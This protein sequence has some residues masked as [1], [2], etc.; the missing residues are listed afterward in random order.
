MKHAVELLRRDPAIALLAGGALVMALVAGV[1]GGPIGFL[2]VLAAGIAAAGVF[3]GGRVMRARL[4]NRRAGPFAQGL[5]DNLGTAGISHG[6]AP[7]GESPGVTRA[8]V[9][10]LRGRFTEGVQTLRDHGQD[11]YAMPWYLVVGEPGAGKTEAI[12]HSSIGFPPGLQDQLQGAGGTLNMNW[13]FAR[14][15]VIL[16]TAGRLLLEDSGADEWT[17][18]LSLLK[19]FRPAC[20]VNGAVLVIPADSLLT[21]DPDTTAQKAA[22]IARQLEALQDSL[23]VR[24][25]V[26][27]VISKSDLITG[28]REFFEGIGDPRAIHQMLGWS[29]ASGL[30]EPFHPSELDRLLAPMLERVRRRRAGLALDAA[31]GAHA[32]DRP[33]DRVDA[34]AEFPGALADLVAP[35]R[36]YLEQVFASGAWSRSPLYLRGVYFNSAMREGDAIDQQLARAVG[37]APGALPGGRA[38]ER[39]RSYFLGDVFKEKVFR[40]RG[41]VTHAS[42]ALATRRRQRAVSIGAALVAVLTLIGLTVAGHL[43]LRERLERPSE[44]WSHLAT[45]ADDPDAY[46]IVHTEDGASIYQGDLVVGTD[47]LPVTVVRLPKFLADRIASDRLGLPSVF[48]PIATVLGDPRSRR[49]AAAR[50]LVASLVVVPVVESAA[51]AV[52]RAEVFD[53]AH[54]EAIAGLLE[55]DAGRVPIKLDPLLRLASPVALPD[56]TVLADLEQ[57]LGALYPESEELGTSLPMQRVLDVYA[58][59][60][61]DEAIGHD[62]PVGDLRQLHA[63]LRG[64]DESERAFWTALS[65]EPVPTPALWR[66]HLAELQAAGERLDAASEGSAP[67]QARM[68][69]VAGL[70]ADRAASRF[71]TL[72]KIATDEQ[73][74]SIERALA[75]ARQRAGIGADELIDRVAALS[76]P[77]QESPDALRPRHESRLNWYRD[78]AS[79]VERSGAPQPGRLADTL[80]RTR[81]DA[82]ARAFAQHPGGYEVATRVITDAL[83]RVAGSRTED[84]IR[85]FLETR[86]YSQTVL[87][88]RIAEQA[89][90]LAPIGRT[91]IPLTALRPHPPEYQPEAAALF[92]EDWAFLGETISREHARAPAGWGQHKQAYEQTDRAV[93]QPYREAIGRYWA[94]DALA[95]LEPDLSEIESWDRARGSLESLDFPAITASLAAELQKAA[96]ALDRLG[97][98]SEQRADL[99]AF[100]DRAL[101]SRLEDSITHWAELDTDANAAARS[102][103]ANT[104]AKF[105]Q[106]YLTPFDADL[107]PARV[108]FGAVVRHALDR[109]VADARE[110]SADAARELASL[111]APF[112]LAI[113]GDA[114]LSLEQMRRITRLCE[115]AVRKPADSDQGTVATRSLS[116]PWVESRLERLRTIGVRPDRWS[117]ALERVLASLPIDEPGSFSIEAPAS[118]ASSL[119]PTT[120]NARRAE[121]AMPAALT[122]LTIRDDGGTERHLSLASPGDSGGRYQWPSERTLTL[123]LSQGPDQR[124]IASATLDAPWGLLS[125]ILR[126]G[127]APDEDDPRRYRVPLVFRTPDRGR[128]YYAWVDV[129]LDRDLPPLGTWPTQDSWPDPEELDRRSRE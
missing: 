59:L 97:L 46:A 119:A 71:E 13:W 10:D 42:D 7:M 58:G 123:D 22:R 61:A 38:W 40:E 109:L 62:G 114:P 78:I 28:F 27:V 32:S 111:G 33:L 41:L 21:D 118:G 9:D 84:T 129:R 57:G 69:G 75:S 5:F 4:R 19:K 54:T 49:D 102:L 51:D 113:D 35:L 14:D 79:A 23:D 92:L 36:A 24:F 45:I 16:D 60:A 18:F 50:G 29:N 64:W 89:R 52:T 103:L 98:A 26:W 67:D 95:G 34:L 44:L 70:A 43:T 108:Y 47:S 124:V 116:D 3:V 15:A 86:P 20:P 25:P 2:G 107:G 125:E 106:R 120:R 37:I 94:T 48:S 65:D 73:R 53:P 55:A 76:E 82:L 128:A 72:L 74:P 83:D 96:D 100:E 31:V 63:A 11:L 115:L 112:P 87:R 68:Q 66:E 105:Q 104:P 93:Y 122:Y 8:R 56:P 17:G 77:V 81:L 30:E 6:D 85:R 99:D 101:I 91:P 90:S 127:V 88:A 80:N 117:R 126:E 39:D 121:P 110:Q 1:L 12:R